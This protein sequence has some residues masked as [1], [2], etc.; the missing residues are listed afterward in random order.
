[1]VI[2][3]AESWYWRNFNHWSLLRQLSSI[4]FYSL[5][6][7]SCF[8][9]FLQPIFEICLVAEMATIWNSWLLLELRSNKS[10]HLYI[11]K[12]CNTDM[13]WMSSHLLQFGQD[14][15]MPECFKINTVIHFCYCSGCFTFCYINSIKDK[16]FH[17]DLK[18]DLFFLRSLP[19]LTQKGTWPRTVPIPAL[20]IVAKNIRVKLAVLLK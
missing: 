14:I 16:N 20:E 12:I 6:H 9:I 3:L 5:W 7:S 1:M 4:A 11:Y 13:V 18:E 17:C 2:Y 8:S 10:L 19:S 15:S